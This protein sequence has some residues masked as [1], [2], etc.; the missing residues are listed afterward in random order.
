M[1]NI[2]LLRNYLKVIF[3][4]IFFAFCLFLFT[5]FS[6]SSFILAYAEEDA[7][8]VSYW[9]FD[10][11]TGLTVVDS[12]KSGNHGTLINGARRYTGVQQ[13]NK[14]QL[15][16]RDD[17]VRVPDSD[18]LDFGT[19]DFTITAWVWLD[20][21]D[22]MRGQPIVIKQDSERVGYSL[23]IDENG[24]PALQGRA[25]NAIRRYA[26]VAETSLISRKW[27]FVAGVGDR[28]N[29][30]RLY[31]DG[32]RKNTT[33]INSFSNQVGSISNSADVTIGG[34]LNTGNYTRGMIDNVRIYRKALT[35]SE[36]LAIYIE[37][38]SKSS[39]PSIPPPST[40]KK[41]N[42]VVIMTDDQ[43]DIDSLSVMPKTKTLLQEQGIR[44]LN[45]FVDFP[46]CC[47]SRV[48]FLTGQYAHNHGILGNLPETDGGVC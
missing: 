35:D 17:Y 22:S 4:N 23:F 26:E 19:G 38:L 16:G 3:R 33:R 21:A 2:I 13:G 32:V 24:R 44:F 43:D 48:S 47:P 6:F 34:N 28:T 36:I 25:K 8:L 37:E 1:K 29:G 12:S 27:H 42:I 39:P 10:E 31:V 18:S 14:L 9:K 45:S 30:Y 7:S 15:D 5:I 40:S 20:K 41:P 11:T 46:V